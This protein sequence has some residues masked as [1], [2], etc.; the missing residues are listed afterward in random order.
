VRTLNITGESSKDLETIVL[1]KR[2]KEALRTLVEGLH[3]SLGEDLV[4]VILFGSKAKGQAKRRSD[5][6][7]LVVVGNRDL[8]TQ[9]R[10]IEQVVET[11]LHHNIYR[12]SPMIYSVE[13]YEERKKMGVPFISEIETDGVVLE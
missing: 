4:K 13:D 5:I 11:E 2:E 9:K 12:L 1:T 10:I 6:D 7:L 8:P 3:Q